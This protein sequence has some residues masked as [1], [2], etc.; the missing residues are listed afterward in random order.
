MEQMAFCDLSHTY[1][2]QVT[3]VSQHVF[4]ILGW[5]ILT[6]PLNNIYHVILRIDNSGRSVIYNFD[7]DSETMLVIIT[8]DI[9]NKREY[10]SLSFDRTG[11]AI[12]F[13][14]VFF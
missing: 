11:I 2:K 4:V 3:N 13:D 12:K 7:H 14:E 6:S 5:G 9:P 8:C 1:H 10:F